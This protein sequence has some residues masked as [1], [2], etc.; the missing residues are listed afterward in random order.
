MQDKTNT[1]TTCKQ[2]YDMFKEGMI[3][4]S[5]RLFHMVALFMSVYLYIEI[6]KW[7]M[8]CT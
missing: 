1:K 8:K 6:N 3:F 4:L 5:G 7:I 2:V